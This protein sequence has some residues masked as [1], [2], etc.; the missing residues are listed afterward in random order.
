MYVCTYIRMYVYIYIYLY[1]VIIPQLSGEGCQILCQLARL[2]LF[3]LRRTSSASSRSQWLPPD[4]N[5]NLW[6]KVITHRTS[7]ANSRSQSPLD[8]NSNLWIKMIPRGPQVQ[9]L[10]AIPTGPEQQPLDQK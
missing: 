1:L 10:D 2:L 7:C 3:L 5:S 6:I 9:A 4:T 8:P